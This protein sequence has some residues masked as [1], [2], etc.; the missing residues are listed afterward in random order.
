M[1]PLM[2][3]L[4]NYLMST[5]QKP[6]KAIF[7]SKCMYKNILLFFNKFDFELSP[8]KKVIYDKNVQMWFYSLVWMFNEIT[9]I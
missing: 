8:E 1:N 3:N 2:W 4:F 6:V 9:K 5:K 7:I